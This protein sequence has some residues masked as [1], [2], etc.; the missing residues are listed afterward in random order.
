[1]C[2][3]GEWGGLDMVVDILC[4]FKVLW[5]GYGINVIKDLV[6]VE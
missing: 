2:Y 1:M 6:L 4:D 5:I 3:V